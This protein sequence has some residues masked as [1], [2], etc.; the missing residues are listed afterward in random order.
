LIFHLPTHLHL[1]S[2]TCP[3]VPQKLNNKAHS[4]IFLLDCALLIHVF[5]SFNVVFGKVFQENNIDISVLPK[6]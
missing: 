6:F 4:D 3:L 5:G 1:T 2:I